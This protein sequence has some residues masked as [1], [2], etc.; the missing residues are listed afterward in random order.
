MRTINIIKA[1]KRADSP[2][3]ELISLVQ[4]TVNFKGGGERILLVCSI[5]SKIDQCL[6]TV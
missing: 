4:Q 1:Y 5:F 3:T 2:H 6:L